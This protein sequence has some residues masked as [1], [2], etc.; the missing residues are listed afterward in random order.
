[1]ES[2]EISSLVH[3]S[4]HLILRGNTCLPSITLSGLLAQQLNWEKNLNKWN[5]EN[6]VQNAKNQLLKVHPDK[7]KD[8]DQKNRYEDFVNAQQLLAIGKYL[9][10]HPEEWNLLKSS[11]ECTQYCFERKQAQ[12]EFPIRHTIQEWVTFPTRW[13]TPSIFIFLASLQSFFP[14]SDP[15]FEL[16]PQI[17]YHEY[18]RFLYDSSLL[19]D[20][21]IYFDF[22]ERKTK[23][24]VERFILHLKYATITTKSFIE[25]KSF[26]FEHMIEFKNP[27]IQQFCTMDPFFSE[28]QRTAEQVLDMYIAKGNLSDK[29]SKDARLRLLQIIAEDSST[30][31]RSDRE[32][33]IRKFASILQ[34]VRI[35][36]VG[37]KRKRQPLLCNVRGSVIHPSDLVSCLPIPT[38]PE[39]LE[40]YRIF[41]TFIYFISF[42]YERNAFM[43]RDLKEDFPLLQTCLPPN[44]QDPFYLLYRKLLSLLK[45][46][47]NKRSSCLLL[48]FHS[49]LPSSSE[50]KVVPLST[51]NRNHI[52]YVMENRKLVC[53]TCFSPFYR[54]H[55]KR[56]LLTSF[57]H[58]LKVGKKWSHV[59]I[60]S[61][62]KRMEQYFFQDQH[63]LFNFLSD[64]IIIP[65]DIVKGKK[66]TRKAF[67]K[68]FLLFHHF[69]RTKQ[70][71][72]PIEKGGHYLCLPI[73]IWKGVVTFLSLT[74]FYRWKH[75]NRANRRLFGTNID[76]MKSF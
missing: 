45:V 29:E 38:H 5:F 69:L 50:Q 44:K 52:V 13:K 65:D 57:F 25:E 40:L 28:Y 11:L 55:P 72:F 26:A 71:P 8:N 22:L 51:V 23:K 2:I 75:V 73:T 42:D 64:S 63:S 3:D 74:D 76:V 59:Q 21:P 16:S 1:M 49:L 17:L 54:M 62:T 9:R 18:H 20:V 32:L 33:F 61:H 35:P 6:L 34:R 53:A 24:L 70:F 14:C 27:I 39:K 58:F 46:A 60:H 36:L 48:A 43:Y 7:Q 12:K 19:M 68:T 10:S 15:T 56:A 31:L 30:F 67:E 47:P 66:Q 41:Q 4:Y 37:W